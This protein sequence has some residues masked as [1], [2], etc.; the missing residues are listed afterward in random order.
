[1]TERCLIINADDYGMCHAA[2]EAV[3]DLFNNGFI[4]SA[5]L[6]TPCPWAEDALSRAVSNKRIN[7]G[8]HLTL[9]SEWQ[10]YRW[11]PVSRTPVPSLLDGG[12]YLFRAVAPLL[13]QARAE[14]VRAEIAAQLDW[15]VSRGFRPTHVDNHMGSLYGLEGQSFLAEVFALCAPHGFAFRLPRSAATFGPVP[16]Q[17]EAALPEIARQADNLGIGILDSLLDF[18]RPLLASDTYETVKDRY[19]C[20]IRGIGTGIN[21]LYVQPALACS[22]L[23]AICPAWQMRVWEHRL[24]RDPDVGRTIE[25][26][27]IKL[28]TWK[29]APFRQRARECSGI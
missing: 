3:E 20:I 22:E 23:K 10:S 13:R 28:T 29:E 16:P 15:M 18:G 12:E 27:G 5:T 1:M 7:V 14:D 6:M 26:E 4:T 25:R 21:E 24:M 11:G 2:N 19:L 17:L 9:N 8:L